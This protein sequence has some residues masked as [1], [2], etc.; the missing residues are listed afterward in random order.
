MSTSARDARHQADGTGP[1]QRIS[2]HKGDLIVRSTYTRP[3]RRRRQLGA[4]LVGL[5]LLAAACSNK[6]DEESVGGGDT[7]PASEGGAT[8]TTS[9]GAATD[10]PDATEAPD[11]TDAPDGTE[12][13]GTD[14]PA[15]TEAPASTAPAVEPVMGG[16]LVVSGE[17]EVANPWTPVAMQCDSYCQQRA[18]TFFD[19]LVTYGDD[20]EVHPFLA[21]SVEPNED[22]TEWTI[23]VRP[24][25][26]FHDGTALDADAVIYNLQQTGTGLLVSK[27]LTDVAKVPNAADPALMDL[28]IEKLDDMSF[29]I[30]TGKNGDPNTPVPWPD[31]DAYLAGQWGLIGSPT[32]LEAVKTDETLAAQPVGTGPFIFESYAPRDRLIVNKNPDYWMQDASGNQLPYLDR[33]EFRVIEDPVTAQQALE[34][35]EIDMFATSSSQVIADFQ[36]LG[37][38][39]DVSLQDEL[40]ET[41]YILIDQSKDNAL[42]DARVRCAMSLA[43]DRVE[44]IDATG[45][46][47]L[48]PANGVFS[49][50]QQ[51]YLDDNGLSLEQ[52]IDAAAALIEEYEAETGQQ[53]TF[54]FGHTPNRINDQVAEL[55][56]GWWNEAG[57]EANDLQV[58]QD[59]FITL[60]LLGDAQFQAFLWRQHAGVGVDQQYFWWHSNGARPDGEL[61]LNFGR[62]NNPAID[63]A[64]DTARSSD[65]PEEAQAAAEEVN[66]QF[67]ENCHYIPLSWTLWGIIGEP[68]VEGLGTFMLPDGSTARDGAGFSGQFWTQTVFL[69]EG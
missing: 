12:P 29:T 16:T 23:T 52:D 17:A 41:T 6:K 68:S 25:I 27:A 56:L 1:T 63:E 38:E 18:R 30:F 55:L 10:P 58:P 50:G 8:V 37:D 33:I 46:G 15:S 44:L 21:E 32:W 69:D 67:A 14:A 5:A 54:E 26:T 47:I 2:D 28:K 7:T 57:I 45:G 34:S 53:A 35:G 39:F 11:G 66:R 19:P 59:Q 9:G 49:P 36:E 3:G 40:T 22:F 24:D 51:G 64:L 60:A 13:E 61:S 48:E 42:A 31:F 62:L 65:D 43:I 4:A 20:L